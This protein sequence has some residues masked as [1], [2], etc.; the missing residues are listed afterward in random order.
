[1]YIKQVGFFFFFCFLLLHLDH[2][3]DKSV[4]HQLLE[5]SRLVVG[6]GSENCS[7][8]CETAKHSLSCYQ[9]MIS[10]G[11]LFPYKLLS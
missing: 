4:D 3:M 5:A 2:K 9:C 6:N 7:F 8:Q 10:V 11:N 1:M